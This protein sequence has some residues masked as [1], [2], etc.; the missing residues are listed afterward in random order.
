MGGKGN[1]FQYADGK[2]KLLMFFGALGSIGDGLQYPLTMFVLSHVI[3]EYGSSSTS[4]SKDTVDQVIILGP[5]NN[6]IA[7]LW[8][9]IK[10]H[11]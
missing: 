1:M 4:L 10:L 6:L 7:Y 2:D 11:Y 8:L 3:N 5:D 9:L